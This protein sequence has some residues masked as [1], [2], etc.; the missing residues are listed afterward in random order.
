MTEVPPSR[1]KVVERGRRL[2]VIDTHTGKPATHEH[3]P[4]V[5][6]PEPADR[7][8]ESTGP[9]RV[10]DRSGN[11]ILTTSR[12]YDLKGPREIVMTEDFSNGLS[13]AVRGG[14]IAMF[15]FGTFAT[16]VF[17]WLWIVPIFILLQP[18]ARAV[19]RQWITARLDQA[20]T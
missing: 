17:P 5:S 8:I 10:D 16:I 7:P 3:A 12:L 19:T 9:R 6:R 18:K 20:A 14:L 2:V 15:V 1:Y 13:R 4:P 11:S